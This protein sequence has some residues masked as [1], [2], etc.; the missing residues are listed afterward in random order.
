MNM[1]SSQTSNK[2]D[3]MTINMGMDINTEFYPPNDLSVALPGLFHT[4]NIYN[5]TGP[6]DHCCLI[7]E[8]LDQDFMD[9][10]TYQFKY[11]EQPSTMLQTSFWQDELSNY[12]LDHL[13]H[14]DSYVKY[15]QGESQGS[16]V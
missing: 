2:I 3:T 15:D 5:F 16:K 4:G 7:Q 14:E 1:S 6:N 11:A 12:K 8:Q 13:K 10:H 9:D